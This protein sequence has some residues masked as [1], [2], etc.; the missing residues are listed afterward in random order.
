MILPL[1][2]EDIINKYI[3]ELNNIEK[4]KKLLREIK[5]KIYKRPDINEKIRCHYDFFNCSISSQF[6]FIKYKNINYDYVLNPY[7]F[8]LKFKSNFKKKL[9]YL[10]HQKYL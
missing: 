8:D 9:K 7:S 3:I 2:I 5:K 6:Y 1:V 10:G 4:N